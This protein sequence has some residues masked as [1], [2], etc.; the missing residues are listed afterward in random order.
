MNFVVVLWCVSLVLW[1]VEAKMGS[2]KRQNPQNKIGDASLT[3]IGRLQP[4]LSI[5]G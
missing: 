4:I 5:F 3:V 1:R 2:K